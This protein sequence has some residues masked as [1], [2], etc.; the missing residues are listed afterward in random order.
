VAKA[1]KVT[2]QYKEENNMFQQYIGLVKILTRNLI[3]TGFKNKKGRKA[4]FSAM[5][6]GLL[7]LCAYIAFNAFVLAD[8]LGKQGFFEE[9]IY[10]LLLGAQIIVIFFGSFAVMSYLFYSKDN[11]LLSSLPVSPRVVFLAK[12]TMAYLAELVF[13]SFILI[14]ALIATGVVGMVN[15]FGIAWHFFITQFV[16]I[17]L[18]PVLPL[19]A[20]SLIFLPVMYAFS[21]FKKRAVGGAVITAV[22]YLGLIVV[23]FALSASMG[24]A[25]SVMADGGFTISDSLASALQSLKTAT[26]FNYPAV[27]ILTNNN[28]LLNLLIFVAGTAI[29]L[30]GVTLLSSFFYKNTLKLFSEG[31]GSSGK[32]GKNARVVEADSLN[33]SLFLKEFR[34]L[35]SSPMLFISS[36]M[37]IIF[38]SAIVFVMR[39]LPSSNGEEVGSGML[40]IAMVNYIAFIMLAGTNFP[41]SIGFSR[42]GKSF[43]TLKSLPISGKT[44]VNSKL[45]FATTITLISAFLTAVIFPFV[46][47]IYNPVAI[48]GLFLTLLFGGFGMNAI[49]LHYDLKNPNLSW[50]NINELTKNNKRQLKPMLLAVGIGMFFLVFGIILGFAPIS[51]T[52][53]YLIY[54]GISAG[55]GFL[56]ASLGYKKLSDNPEGLFNAIE[57]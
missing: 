51:S 57:G 45:F 15:N 27:S 28:V 22:M 23:S 38:P 13:A 36:L 31:Q 43:Y 54:F 10:A 37:G 33:K 5:I 30:A 47:G 49:T 8:S 26:A 3:G 48:F 52:A 42:E 56:L 35:V 14:P 18:I 50:N 34:T 6:A 21:F 32:K 1:H 9:F 20:V 53:V 4:M 2:N 55:A 16:V 17:L 19:V 29:I 24:S 44:L 40:S 12:F 7:L 11:A 41:A 46:S 39:V 25:I